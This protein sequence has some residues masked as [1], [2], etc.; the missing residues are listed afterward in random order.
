MSYV[1]LERVIDKA[2]GSVYKLVILASSRAL[3][4]AE[5]LPP[6]ISNVDKQTKCTKISLMEIAEEKVFLNKS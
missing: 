2:G 1:P 4:I 6:L 5:G 3:E